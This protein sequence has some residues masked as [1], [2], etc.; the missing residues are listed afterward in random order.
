[1]QSRSRRVRLSVTI[2]FLSVFLL[3]DDGCEPPAGNADLTLLELDD[4][5]VNVLTGFD[6]LTTQYSV[7]VAKN[8]ITVRAEPADP[9]STIV[10]FYLGGD[11]PMTGTEIDLNMQ[12]GITVIVVYVTAPQG[13]TRSYLISVTHDQPATT[14]TINVA[15]TSNVLQPN[16]Y[17]MDLTV[18]T[19]SLP[20]GASSLPFTAEVS[21]VARLPRW[22]MQPASNIV[23]GGIQQAV[24][25]EV[26]VTVQAR[27]GASGDDV[28]LNEDASAITPGL[29]SYCLFPDLQVCD[30]ANDLDPNDPS[31]GNSDCLGG[32]EGVP[33]LPPVLVI[34]LPV[35][36]D[37]GP[38]GACEAIGEGFADDNSACDV[39]GTCILDDLDIPLTPGTMDLT[40]DP[41]GDILFGFADQNVPDLTLCPDPDP[42]EC[43][44]PFHAD[45][46]YDI[47]AAV[48]GDPAPP[49]GLRG[50]LMP[51]LLALQ[52]AMAEP[53]GVCAGQTTLGCLTDTDCGAAAPCD[54]VS[55]EGVSMPSPDASLLAIPIGNP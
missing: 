21:G 42:D 2:L 23:P 17:G 53:G 25:N 34:D 15:C 51:L 7:T 47:P 39:N 43:T 49:T 6:P 8:P 31:M 35:S 46:S 1:M 3:G 41:S 52:C 12:L 44:Q 48:Y 24:L 4:E 38:G 36:T 9:G 10:V 27:S 33:C 18:K 19:P 20:D 29:T 40:P 14:K 54:F 22:I 45:G 16:F 50:Y 11:F 30:P 28:L 32:M 55:V 5:G 13:K 37:C 26:A